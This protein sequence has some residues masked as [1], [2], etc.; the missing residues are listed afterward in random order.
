MGACVALPEPDVEAEWDGERGLR[1]G[2]ALAVAV[3]R[4][5]DS[6]RETVGLTVRD[7]YRE[8]EGVSVAEKVCV[9]G[10]EEVWEGDSLEVAEREGVPDM[11]RVHVD[12]VTLDV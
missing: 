11:E 8:W 4:D 2:V 1:E 9:R 5:M 10:R 7:Q 3:E 12:G 6:D